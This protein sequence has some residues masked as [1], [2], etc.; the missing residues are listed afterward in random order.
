MFGRSSGGKD[1]RDNVDT[2]YL[3]LIKSVSSSYAAC[4]AFLKVDDDE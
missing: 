3:L 1:E 4:S 2:V